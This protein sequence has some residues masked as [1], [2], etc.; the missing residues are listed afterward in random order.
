MMVA[1]VIIGGRGRCLDAGC[2]VRQPFIAFP[3]TLK[4]MWLPIENGL[5]GSRGSSLGSRVHGDFAPLQSRMDKKY[6]AA[7]KRNGFL[8]LAVAVCSS[9]EG[10]AA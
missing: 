3:C 2:G 10:V 8:V 1:I 5:G 4:K 7:E 9:T 6:L